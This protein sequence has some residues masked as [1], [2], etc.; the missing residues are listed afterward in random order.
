M[1]QPTVS[2][3]IPIYNGEAYVERIFDNFSKIKIQT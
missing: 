2:I 3:N 1:S